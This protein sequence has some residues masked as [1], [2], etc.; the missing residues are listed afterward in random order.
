MAHKRDSQGVCFCPGDYRTFLREHTETGKIVPGIFYN[1]AGIRIGTHEG[2]PFYTIGQR[3]R[4]G[5]YQNQA[6]F[7]KQ[8]IPETNAVIICNR[9]QA[10]EHNGMYLSHWYLVAPMKS[11]EAMMKLSLKYATA[12]KPTVVGLHLPPTT[13]CMSAC[14]NR[15]RPL[16]ADKRRYSIETTLYWVEELSMP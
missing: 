13:V 14:T 16:P 1:E 12:N 11:S 2:Y 7:V 9:L 6:L 8:I 15:W 4:L 5:I 3:R 10:L